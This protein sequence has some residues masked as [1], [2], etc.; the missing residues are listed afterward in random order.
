MNN[1]KITILS[2][3]TIKDALKKMDIEKINTLI[4][5]NNKKKVIGV[6]TVGDFRRAVFNGIDI[7][8]EISTAVNKKFLYLIKGFSKTKAEEIFYNNK[9]VLDIPVLNKKFQ[10]IK[11]IT[12]KSIFFSKKEKYSLKN[13]PLVI[14]AGGKGT[15]LDPFTRILPKSLIPYGNDP[16]IQIIV[17]NFKKFGLNKFYISISEKEKGGMI[18]AYFQDTTTSRN[19]KYIEE[20]KQLGT[21]G[22]LG[23]LKKKLSTTFFLSNCDIIINTHYP[24]IMEFHKENNNDLTLIVSMRNFVIP[25]GICD[26]D[27]CGKLKNIKEKP[28]HNFFVNTGFYIIEPKILNLIPNNKKFDMVQLIDKVTKNGF[29]IKVFPISENSWIDIGQWDE[30]KKNTNK[31]YFQDKTT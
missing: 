9:L 15:R 4:I 5:V 21:A 30:Y 18:K 3:L 14:M 11:I 6:F 25:Y 17:N 12:R 29:K 2:T 10:L 28:E 23:L 31:F 22:S 8:S 19:I 20:K 27:N 24:T 13:V 1:K 26:F 7:E 16:V